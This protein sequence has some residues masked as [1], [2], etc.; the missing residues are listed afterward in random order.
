M[1]ES[2]GA[3]SRRVARLYR[4]CDNGMIRW[5][6]DWL[7]CFLLFFIERYGI[8]R[9]HG[10]RQMFSL[11]DASIQHP[12]AQQERVPEELLSV[13]AF[14]VPLI[15][16]IL[17]S[18]VQKSRSARINTA[19]LGLVLSI[20]FT[21]FVTELFK[22]LVGRPRPDFLDRCQ[23][24]ILSIVPDTQHYT[25]ELHTYQICTADANTSRVKDGFKS[26]PSGHS[27]M[28]F[29]GLTYLAWYLR[30][31]LNALVLKWAQYAYS[32][33]ETTPND[34]SIHQQLEEGTID[35]EERR[36]LETPYVLALA[37]VVMPAVP[38]M[39]AGYVAA[40][41]LMD[42]RHHPTDVLAGSLLGFSIAS[43]IF[44]TYHPRNIMKA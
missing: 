27:S 16:V 11:N 43:M 28:S 17:L 40:I 24:D 32:D 6:V 37:S 23:P 26:F 22:K 25:S 10:F 34:D 44:F 5:A 35:A 1:S 2:L 21:G 36:Q 4:H 18:L 39:I 19:I 15:S 33:Y 3:L 41:R 7:G 30:G 31:T 20:T 8:H 12:F 9:L 14:W 13:L 29:A 38:L 42:Y